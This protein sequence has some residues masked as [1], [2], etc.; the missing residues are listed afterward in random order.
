LDS[1]WR[2]KEPNLQSEEN[3]VNIEKHQKKKKKKQELTLVLPHVGM[4]NAAAL[5]DGLQCVVLRNNSR[6]HDRSGS[7][8]GFQ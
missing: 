8:R 7:E 5:N 1:A 3:R 6:H 4:Y 2:S